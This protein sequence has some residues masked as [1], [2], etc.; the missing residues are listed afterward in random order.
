MLKRFEEEQLTTAKKFS[1]ST[2]HKPRLE[3]EYTRQLITFL[4]ADEANNHKRWKEEFKDLNH[5]GRII[6]IYGSILHNY[7]KAADIDIMIATNDNDNP[8][9]I[10]ED[11]RKIEQQ[12]PKKIHPIILT[13]EDLLLNIQQEQEAI[14]NIIKT[15]IVLYGQ[16]DYVEVIK[17]ITSS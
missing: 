11:I 5:D 10:K 1:H 15:A 13:K 9:K 7:Q 17:H 14:V 6:M 4:L 8:T 16:N 12:L 3:E 2:I